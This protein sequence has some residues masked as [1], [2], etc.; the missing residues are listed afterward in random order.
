MDFFNVLK[1]AHVVGRLAINCLLVVVADVVLIFYLEWGVFSG[2]GTAGGSVWAG[3]QDDQG[4][5]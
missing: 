4:K 5:P 2:G 3:S 1:G